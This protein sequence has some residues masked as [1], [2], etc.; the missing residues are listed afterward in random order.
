MKKTV[1]L[2]VICLTLMS[3]EDIFRDD[4]INYVPL[5][6]NPT[7]L[8]EINIGNYGSSVY[9]K[10]LGT[11]SENRTAVFKIRGQNYSISELSR[12]SDTGVI[13]F[14]YQPREGFIGED[15]VEIITPVERNGSEIFGETN[16]L[17]FF[18]N[19]GQ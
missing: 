9:E 12:N 14:R 3:C 8:F 19:I 10:S 17:E 15:Y 7:T 2:L 18:I 13:T 4:D 11:F 16:T 6:D 1:L 5:A